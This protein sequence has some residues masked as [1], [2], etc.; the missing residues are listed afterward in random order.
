MAGE[1]DICLEQ[2]QEAQQRTKVSLAVAL[3][4]LTVFGPISMD[5]YLPVLPALSADLG[6]TTSTAQ[7]TIS[8]CLFGLAAGQLITGPLSDRY[9]RR[10][11]LLIGITAYILT[12]IACAVSP[13]IEVLVVARFAQGLAGGAGV[14]IAQAAGRDLFSGG[15]LV[16]YYARLTVL[17]GLAAVIG[18]VIGGQ[19]AALTDWRGVFAFLAGVGLVILVVSTLVFTETQPRERRTRGGVIASGHQMRRLLIDP[20][21][22]TPVLIMGLTNAA[23]FAYLS[24]ATFTLQGTYGLSP[25]GYSIAF[26]LNSVGFMAFGFAGG[27]LAALWSVTGALVAGLILA[28][29]GAAGLF[30]TGLFG[31]PLPVF[32]V[33]LFA[34]VAGIAFASP[35]ATM[36]A[37]ADHPELAGT[38]SSLLGLAR[39]AAGGV[40][41]PLVGLAGASVGIGL[42][43]VTLASTAAAVTVLAWSRT[44]R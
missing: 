35:P 22:L 32:V 26:G 8:A 14:V 28:V 12:S 18:P 15:R 11:P 23:L 44:T 7:V 41:A 17:G 40:A 30:V 10:R 37:L 13:T 38:A 31:L 25:Q 16:R 33:T 27:R 5:L 1:T 2:R 34:M 42:G 20:A 29:L 6:A 9:G 43:V 24:G 39:Y 3:G 21:F 19:L 4:L 36:L